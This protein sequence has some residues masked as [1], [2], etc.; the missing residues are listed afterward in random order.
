M[1]PGPTLRRAVSRWQI[2]GIAV[3]GVVGSGVYLLPAAAAALLGF[4]SLWAVLVA[5][6][7]VTLLVLCFAEASSHFDQPG[8]AYVYT[9]EAFG[10]F[11]GFEVGWMM[12]LTKIAT[13]AALTNGLVQA[14]GFF[15]P[16]MSTGANRLALIAAVF[17]FITGINLVGVR[18]A[19]RITAGFAVV[20]V[21]PLLVLVVVGLF[22]ID[23][24]RIS[25]A[26]ATG[27]S[28]LG[29][30]ALLLLFAYAG[31]ENA[32]AAAGE[33]RDPRRDVP[34]ALIT[35]ILGVTALYFLIQLVALGVLPD[36]AA[37]AG[38]APLAAAA[39]VLMG[40]WGGVL[41]TVGAVVSILGTIVNMAFNGPRYLFA[42]AEDGYGPRALTRVHPR[43][44]TPHVAILAQVSI[45]FLL[46]VSGTFIQLALLSMITRLSTY[47]GTAAAVP[48]LRRRLP[49]TGST[50]R[51]PGG[52]LIPIAALALC[53]V[54]L[55]S[56]TAANLV[57]GAV[58]LVAGVP[59]YLLRREPTFDSA[60]IPAR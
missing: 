27:S 42:L 33:Y 18:G 52:S 12:F 17:A 51:L 60:V 25:F 59:I 30:A 49:R 58:A 55:V 31:F 39:E 56:T 15:S 9:R 36:L 32:A 8:S 38:G 14:I 40:G 50:V 54:F 1:S 13:M 24:S 29:Q 21:V 2:T 10:R 46:A 23:F 57:A 4:A 3:N 6:L 45:A 5:G 47:V 19:A 53:G 41:L 34:F 7:A 16:G 43:W 37:H 20:K 22:S 11:V 35:M 26:P 44:R 48:V 28:D